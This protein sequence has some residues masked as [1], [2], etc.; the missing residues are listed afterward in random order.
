M[1]DLASTQEAQGK[2]D[3]AILTVARAA[4]L[5]NHT[6][7]EGLDEDLTHLAKLLRARRKREAPGAAEIAKAA[8]AATEPPKMLRITT[9][10]RGTI[11]LDNA[12]LQAETPVEKL[13]PGPH[14]IVYTPEGGKAAVRVHA[15]FTPGHDYS[16]FLNAASP[17]QWTL[18]NL[19]DFNL[20]AITVSD[21]V[22]RPDKSWVAVL[23]AGSKLYL[24]TS[25]D[26]ITWDT[27]WE[28]P[29]NGMANNLDGTITVDDRGTLWLAWIS[30]PGSLQPRGSG[31]YSL[32]VSSSPDGKTWSPP[33]PDRQR[34]HQLAAGK[35]PMVA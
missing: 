22:R 28:M 7:F 20:G 32:W 31:G 6:T 15:A 4:T 35:A 3:D 16:L 17:F 23:D 19:G 12:P 18:T 24:T 13:P 10:T 25:R 34:Q 30:N 14:E 29:H 33:R 21:L 8:P 9:A 2:F 5:R 26:L 27:P 1:E 11:T